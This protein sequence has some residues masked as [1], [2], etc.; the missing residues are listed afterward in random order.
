MLL[1]V[2]KCCVILGCGLI[3][4]VG[5]GVSFTAAAPVS[6]REGGMCFRGGGMVLL[7]SVLGVGESGE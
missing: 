2:P 6:M 5:N 1:V 3:L 7:V 4:S